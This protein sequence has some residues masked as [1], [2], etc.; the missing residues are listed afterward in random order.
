MI[1]EKQQEIDDLQIQYD[2]VL[3]ESGQ[4][5]KYDTGYSNGNYKNGKS[6]NQNE[7]ENRG[8]SGNKPKNEQYETRKK[9]RN[10]ESFNGT[11]GRG[12]QGRK[13]QNNRR[14]ANRNQ[15]EELAIN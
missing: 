13:G 7:S 5:P 8:Y 2:Q 4:G 10:D 1:T 6:Q 15:D 3:S 11:R 14:G 9:D 12:G